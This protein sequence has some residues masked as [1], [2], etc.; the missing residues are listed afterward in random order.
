MSICVLQKARRISGKD[1]LLTQY[2]GFIYPNITYCI[3]VWGT[4]SLNNGCPFSH[5]INGNQIDNI[6]SIQSTFKAVI[7]IFENII[8]V[9]WVSHVIY[10]PCYLDIK[11]TYLP[12]VF[13]Q[14]SLKAV[15][16]FT[17]MDKLQFQHGQVGA[18][19]I[20]CG[21]KLPIQL[22]TLPLSP[23]KFANG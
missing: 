22:Q 17:N 4:T 23:L 13:I 14:S 2:N 20:K 18:S 12:I 15:P 3:E 7:R 8:A 10:Y 19:I 16:L 21:I 5:Y 6:I 1:S 11:T 9:W